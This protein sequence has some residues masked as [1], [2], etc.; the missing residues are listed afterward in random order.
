MKIIVT[1][2]A[3]R[4][5]LSIITALYQD[6]E[7]LLTG[8]VERKEHKYINQDIGILAGIGNTGLIVADNLE[9]IIGEG[10]VLIDFTT[11][12]ATIEHLKYAYGYQKKMVIGTTGLSDD[13]ITQIK[14]CSQKIAVVFSPNMSIGVNLLFKI[15]E[16][17][18]KILGPEFDIEILEAHHH[19][20]K[21]APSG[22]AKKLAE[23]VALSLNRDLKKVGIYG[24]EGLVGERK[25]EEIGILSVRGGDIVGEHNVIFAGE[26]ER[27]ELI[28]KAHSRMTFAKGALKAAKWLSNKSCGL[29]N[30]ND[31]L[32]I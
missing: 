14:E 27:L 22:T 17:V 16:E 5:G 21:D 4:M 15:T 31:V 3:G 25:E 28:H 29:Y 18:T 1:G 9:E 20:K 11:P 10:D 23:I 19:H 8:V 7:L 24:R 13:Q 30:M 2:A 6:P 12:Q 32:G 26:G